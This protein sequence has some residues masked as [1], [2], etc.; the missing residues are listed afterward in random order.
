MT[1]I[2]LILLIIVLVCFF[3]MRFSEGFTPYGPYQIGN[4]EYQYG[5]GNAPA[6][7]NALPGELQYG[8]NAGVPSVN[9]VPPG[10]PQNVWAEYK[11]QPM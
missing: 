7:V 5:L 4:N 3:C 11:K 8:Q 2:I 10:N 6:G 9:P 1:Q